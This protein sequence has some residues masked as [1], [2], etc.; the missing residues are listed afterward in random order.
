MADG[1]NMVYH[2]MEHDPAMKMK[3]LLETFNNIM[4]TE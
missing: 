3:E 1:Q 2:V 4:A